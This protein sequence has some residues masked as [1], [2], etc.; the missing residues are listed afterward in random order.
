MT[1]PMNAVPANVTAPEP[2]PEPVPEAVLARAAELYLDLH[3]HPELSGAEE[4]TAARF[5][6]ALTAAGL[7]VE[8]GIGGHGV[9]GV[10]ENGPGPV[11]MIRAELDALPVREET[12]LPYAS[13]ATAPGPDGAPVPVMHACGHDMHLACLA[14]AATR[15]AGEPERWRGTLLVVGQPAEET[16]G[17]AAA[18]LTD[19]LYQRFPVPGEVLA[20]HVVPLPAGMV[21]HANGPLLAG[22]T[23]LEIVLHGRGGHAAT[24]Q[25]AADP[26][27]AAAAVVLRLQTV[28]SRETGPGE[29]LVL[30]VG[31]VRAGTPGAGNVIADTATL[32]VT[33]RAFSD[34]ALDRAVA[35][36]QRIVR[37]EAAAAPEPA[38]PAPEVRVLSRSGPTGPDAELTADLRR[39]HEAAFGARR[40]TRW[41]PSMATEDVALYGEAG[42]RLH[43]V[44]GIRTGYWM[45]GAAGPRQWAA[46]GEGT[47]PADAARRLAALPP[48]HSPRFAPHPRLTLE[49]G[50]AAMTVAVRARMPS[51]KVGSHVPQPLEGPW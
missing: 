18:M 36:V 43:G 2:E 41:Q 37:A 14:G 47:G 28:V 6:A 27:I 44:P 7:R 38:P 20:Q 1:A 24:P 32:Q 15:L 26:V 45:L 13:T 3:R 5:G 23:T 49:A 31:S 50:I 46:A 8:S 39:A 22:S 51:V 34:A 21:A 11:V 9:V 42:V 48:N 25:L 19:G 33:V 17:G 35:A 16:L 12:G 4:R 30:T 10:L 40:V 29:P